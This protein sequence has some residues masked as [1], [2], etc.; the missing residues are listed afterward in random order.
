M[1]ETTRN[2]ISLQR[3][4][5]AAAGGR[6][7]KYYVFGFSHFVAK[8]YSIRD[9]VARGEFNDSCYCVRIQPHEAWHIR[10][11]ASN[12]QESMSYEWNRVL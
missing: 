12:N 6:K 4:A 11:V 8:T 7:S 9:D 2:R 5:A 1:H 3:W 10:H